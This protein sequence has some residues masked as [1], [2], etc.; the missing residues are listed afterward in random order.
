MCTT[1]QCK[2]GMTRHKSSVARIAPGPNEVLVLC[3]GAL[4][5]SPLNPVTLYHSNCSMP[6]GCERTVP[7]EGNR[8]L[9][10]RTGELLS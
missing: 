3:E 7:K 9:R 8:L 6:F 2:M 1:T 5:I 10:L 4:S